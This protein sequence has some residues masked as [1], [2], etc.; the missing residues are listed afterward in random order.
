M[1][2]YLSH[3]AN[4]AFNRVAVVQ[5]RLASRFEGAASVAPT[6]DNQQRVAE[7]P[8]SHSQA[9]QPEQLQPAPARQ[10]QAEPTAA[11]THTKPSSTPVLEAPAIHPQIQPA[12]TLEQAPVAIEPQILVQ[13]L[14]R[15]RP[16]EQP[17]LV[18]VPIPSSA[19][20]T[21]PGQPGV[22]RIIERSLVIEH[23]TEASVS[24]KADMSPLSHRLEPKVE[25]PTAANKT[26]HIQTR[27][28][29]PEPVF[30]AITQRP[31]VQAE[32]VAPAPSIQVS[33]GRIEI[34]ANPAT[35]TQSAKAKAAPAT[36]SLDDYLKQRKGDR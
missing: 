16:Q 12:T 7:A 14:V 8:V 6:E 29:A 13:Q 35:T 31:L 11:T 10:P 21:E 1:S 32:A 2:Q 34:R 36:L 25:V 3:I 4:L 20:T 26:P 15:E 23:Q 17:L 27:I 19:A 24:N 28:P 18:S 30:Q 5:P 9:I 22:E 33:I